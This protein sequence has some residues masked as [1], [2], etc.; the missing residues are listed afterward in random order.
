MYESMNQERDNLTSLSEFFQELIENLGDGI[1]DVNRIV[2]SCH[3][4]LRQVPFLA[5]KMEWREGC[6]RQLLRWYLLCTKLDNVGKNG[7]GGTG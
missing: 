3:H 1:S 5:L 7:R 6:C 2:F 4:G